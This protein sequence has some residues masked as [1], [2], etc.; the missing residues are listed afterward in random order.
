MTVREGLSARRGS[1]QQRP[2]GDAEPCEPLLPSVERLLADTELTDDLGHRS[3]RL[4]LPQSESYLL[5]RKMLLPHPKNPPFLVMP[6][7][8]NLTSR[9]DQETGRTSTTRRRLLP[10][11]RIHFS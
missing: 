10:H 8:K 11:G 1:F 3:A 5:F 7:S 4:S 2:A 9:M 6:R